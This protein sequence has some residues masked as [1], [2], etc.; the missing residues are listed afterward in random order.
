M[1]R[2]AAE[3]LYTALLTLEPA[4]AEDGAGGGGEGASAE[5]VEAALEL[6]EATAWDGPLPAVRAA[7]AQVFSLLR[8]PEPVPVGGQAGG[9]GGGDGSSASGKQQAAAEARQGSAADENASYAAL[10]THTAR[11]M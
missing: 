2:Y 10:L 8:L 4:D 1:R 6:V 7:R 11:G 3:Q 9:G 5:D